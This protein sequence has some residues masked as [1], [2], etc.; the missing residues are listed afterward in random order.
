MISKH[1]LE[2]SWLKI[3]ADFSYFIFLY[4]M[5]ITSAGFSFESNGLLDILHV[6]NLNLFHKM[7]SYLPP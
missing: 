1:S 4:F 2:P 3:C 7:K 5:S 6:T